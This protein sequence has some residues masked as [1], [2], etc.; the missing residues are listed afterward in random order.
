MNGPVVIKLGGA[1]LEDDAA[2]GRLLAALKP[3][4]AR[5]PLLIVHGGG[6][7][8]EQTL[9]AM[10]MPSSKKDGLRITPPEQMAVIAGAL[11]GTCNKHMT[12]L[13]SMAGYR[14]VGLCLGDGQM[15]ECDLLDPE[16]G[17]VGKPSGQGDGRLLQLLLGQG[18]T[19]VISSIAMGR[20][21]GLLNVNADQAAVA[22]A[23]LLPGAEL[24]LL[25]D[26]DGILDGDK[27]LIPEMTSAL[28]EQ[29]IA[30]G[31]IHGGMTVKVKA[32][33]EAAQGLG[34]AIAVASWKTPEKLQLLLAGEAAGT[35]VRP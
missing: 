29:L 32:A 14:A 24:L 11:A 10:N 23:Q 6:I 5:R 31:V 27:Q 35:W 4:A 12:A 21:G 34:R 19:P 30:S 15:V 3:V 9:A 17:R 22:I 13:A 25:S 26:V 7:I 16:L 33:L 1:V 8:V 20:D 28:A 2:L 18:F